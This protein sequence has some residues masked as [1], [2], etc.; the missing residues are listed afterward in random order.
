MLCTWVTQ[1]RVGRTGGKE[2]EAGDQGSRPSSVMTSVWI[3]P[4]EGTESPLPP[5]SL[6]PPAGGNMVGAKTALLDQEVEVIC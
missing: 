1:G 5:L 3:V 4:L 6:F 2:E